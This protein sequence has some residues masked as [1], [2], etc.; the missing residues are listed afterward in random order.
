MENL[1]DKLFP[2]EQIQK[3][4]EIF[5]KCYTHSWIKLSNINKNKKN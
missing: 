2:K 4:L 1:Y 3:D 5:Q